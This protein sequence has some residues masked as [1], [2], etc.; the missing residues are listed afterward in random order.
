[1]FNTTTPK[2]I[3]TTLLVIASIMTGVFLMQIRTYA[4]GNS[5][6]GN[7]SSSKT[8]TGSS[9]SKN[10][11]ESDTEDNSNSA[12]SQN[13]SSKNMF[14]LDD[15]KEGELSAARDRLEANKNLSSD[16]RAAQIANL[17]KMSATQLCT[18]LTA[19]FAARLEMY[20]KLY[21]AQKTRDTQ[22]IEKLSSLVTRLQATD[23]DVSGLSNAVDRLKQY[24]SNFD[25]AYLT[26]S[27]KLSAAQA[28]AC[29]SDQVTT[30][31]Q[32]VSQALELLNAWRSSY[33]TLTQYIRGDLK[34]ALQ[35]LKQSRESAGSSSVTSSLSSTTTN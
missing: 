5:S 30:Y 7:N 16:A 8:A 25:A 32:A 35:A 33:Q 19:N 23:A 18:T 2:R 31:K 20:D 3:F 10:E 29:S 11:S 26:F 15:S 34:T 6:S 14:G 1:M 22:L 27:S 21:Q 17:R 13:S 12:A 28:N 4:E 9:S 24:V